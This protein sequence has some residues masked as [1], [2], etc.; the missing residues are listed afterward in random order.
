MRWEEAGRLEKVED[1]SFLL[2]SVAGVSLRC[3]A[4]HLA[5]PV[6]ASAGASPSRSRSP[7]HVLGLPVRFASQW[8]PQ[9]GYSSSLPVL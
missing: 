6:D 3:A 4:W 5:L 7:P 9:V 2:S 8:Q 1:N